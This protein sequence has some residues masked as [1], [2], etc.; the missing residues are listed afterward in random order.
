MNAGEALG[1]HE[2][3]SI[4]YALEHLDCV[5]SRVVLL[6]IQTAELREPRSVSRPRRTHKILRPTR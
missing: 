2:L 3:G 5:N 6:E 1:A 4:E